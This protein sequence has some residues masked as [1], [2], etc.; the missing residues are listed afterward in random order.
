MFL[1]EELDETKEYKTKQNKTTIITNIS[2]SV[3]IL[4]MYLVGMISNEV[5][6]E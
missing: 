2:T 6:Y 4:M 1:E 5:E 3:T